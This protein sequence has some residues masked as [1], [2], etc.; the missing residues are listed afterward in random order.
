MER[1]Y[2]RCQKENKKE[3]GATTAAPARILVFTKTQGFRHQSIGDGQQA[4]LK[5]GEKNNWQ[6]AF[7]EDSRAFSPENLGRYAVVVFL[8]TTGDVLNEEQ[9]SAFQSYIETGGGFVGV[10]SASDT[11]HGW[12]WY[13]QLVGAYFKNHP[14]VQS[15]T[16]IVEKDDTAATSHLGDTWV[17]SDEWYNFN[18]NPRDNV[19]VL[20]SLDESSYDPGNGAMGD[21]PIAWQREMGQGR[22]FYTGLGH[23][24]ATYTNPLFL[25]HLTGGIRWAAGMED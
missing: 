6:V 24:I 22:T 1:K 5:L 8:N 15:A 9:Q 2:R 19:E 7:S 20:L 14:K 11:E 13:S 17:H 12:L 25:E 3:I 4:L 10:H 16:L 21:H 23:T 18:R